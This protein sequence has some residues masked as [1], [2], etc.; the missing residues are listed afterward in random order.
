M[1]TLLCS[2]TYK[3]FWDSLQGNVL[4]LEELT[5]KVISGIKPVAEQLNVGKLE[6]YFRA[7]RQASDIATRT[8]LY[9]SS[10]G[11][12]N[13]GETYEFQAG[14]DGISSFTFFPVKGHAFTAEEKASLHFIASTL[15]VFGGRA[16]LMGFAYKASTSDLM[17]GAANQ[18]F[19]RQTGEKLHAAGVLKNY[20]GIFINLKNF[21]YVNKTVQPK[22]GD[23]ALK[24]LVRRVSASFSENEI[25]ARLGGDNFFALVKD[26]NVQKFVENF[27]VL[28]IAE[29]P[30]FGNARVTLRLRMGIYNIG[31]HDT[32]S[33]VMNCSSIALNIARNPQTED[34]VYFEPKMF[35]RA[36]YQKEIS[37]V[38]PE[39]HK[40]EEF[41]VYYQPKINIRDNT[42]H[43]VEA[44]V[45][46]FRNGKWIM[47]MEF[48]P[49]LESEGAICKLDF[50]VF[51]RVCR[52]I[53]QWI[54]AELDPVRVSVN[55]SKLHLKNSNLAKDILNV[56]KRYR[57]PSKY[58][59]VELTEVSDFEDNVAFASFVNE[60]RASGVAVSI[61]DFGAGYSTFNVVKNLKVD[62]VK[63]DKSLF[64]DLQHQRDSVIVENLVAMI[65]G[66]DMEV[67]A[68]GIE[69]EEQLDFLKKY[70][71]DVVQGFY[72]DKPMPY[73]EFTK[74]LADGKFYKT[75]H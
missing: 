12:E 8:I 73:N 54:E 58:I 2:S 47:P 74:R 66:L 28:T 5:S 71:C 10:Q 49:V 29:V 38:F 40:N 27:S 1:E 4:S 75:S 24:I 67:V 15:F 62:V 65:K 9:T 18:A 46:W 64:D 69:T 56:M 22:N 13:V 39:A 43:G 52:N 16:Q 25:F 31:E 37:A 6:N 3:S 11:M 51:E 45:R 19:L 61:D 72:F 60:I 14:M 59:E 17:T 20:T 48:L 50:Y 53:R 34:V 63:L 30:E 68:E 33:V 42:L 7:S 23:L 44:L 41:A 36:L 70:G 55:F 26:E 32:M 21:K 35:E 57:V